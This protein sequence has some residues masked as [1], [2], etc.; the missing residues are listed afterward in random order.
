MNMNSVHMAE[1]MGYEFNHED[2]A[3]EVKDED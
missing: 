1:K 3:Y 2:T